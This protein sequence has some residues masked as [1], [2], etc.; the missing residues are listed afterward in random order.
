MLDVTTPTVIVGCDI[1]ETSVMP[2]YVTAARERAMR[3]L[4][5]PSR[6]SIKATRFH[7]NLHTPNFIQQTISLTN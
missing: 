4:R 1:F 5:V 2:A 7:G 6:G 3:A